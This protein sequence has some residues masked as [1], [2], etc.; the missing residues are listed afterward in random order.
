VRTYNSNLS[1]GNWS[2]TASVIVRSAPPAPII[3]GGSSSPRPLISWQAEGQVRA[4]IQISGKTNAVISAEKEYQ[5][6]D[7][8]PDGLIAVQVRVQN[9]FGLWSPWASTTASIQNSPSGKIALSADVNNFSVSL[10]VSSQYPQNY[11][12]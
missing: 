7:L 10:S 4:E 1:A 5:W 3:T 2:D 8:L 6:P 11:I 9:L 12:Y